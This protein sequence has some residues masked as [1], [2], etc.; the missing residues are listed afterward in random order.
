M[1]EHSYNSDSVSNH[2]SDSNPPAKADP[3]SDSILQDLAQSLKHSTYACGGT[4]AIQGYD[5]KL[6]D[7]TAFPVVIRWDSSEAIEKLTFPCALDAETDGNGEL[8]KLVKTSEPASFGL[9]G[10][11]VIDESYRKAVKLD[12]S[13]FASTFCPY[14]AGIIDAIGQALLPRDSSTSQGIRAELYKLNVSISCRSSRS[15]H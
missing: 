6:T 2:S 14:Q 7:G 13:A 10:K 5:Q 12:P 15:S 3:V 8:K 1:S 9:N 4:V 11:D